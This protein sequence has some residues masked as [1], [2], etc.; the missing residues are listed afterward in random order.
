[1]SIGSLHGRPAALVAMAA[2]STSDLR[3]KPAMHSGDHLVYTAQTY[4][5]QLM[6]HVGSI[7][8]G[9]RLPHLLASGPTGPGRTRAGP[10]GLMSTYSGQKDA[11][12]PN[13][14]PM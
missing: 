8:P 1:V 3:P 14:Y 6:R 10:G 7:S 13:R 11:L 12:P 9:H 5:P 4:A 2:S